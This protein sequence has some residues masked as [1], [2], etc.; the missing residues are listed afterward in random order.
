MLCFTSG[1]TDVCVCVCVC[2]YVCVCVCV[3]ACV[4]APANVSSVHVHTSLR[5][6]RVETSLAASHGKTEDTKSNL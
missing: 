4:C 6:R 5:G 3:C 2:L 1:L